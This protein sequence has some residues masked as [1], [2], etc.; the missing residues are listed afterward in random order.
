MDKYKI[1]VKGIV[2]YNDKYLIVEK[3]Y[4]DRI[5]DPYQ[6]EF[7]DGK[8]EFGESP[9]KGVIRLI[10]QSTGLGAE[11]SKILYT[12]SFM[13]G[14]VCNLGITY[15]CLSA[16]EEVIL[17]EELNSYKWITKEEFGDYID[18]KAML[19]DIEKAELIM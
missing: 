7:V 11:I 9:D 18:N 8:V 15:L 6:W 16:S 19:Q 10:Q 13:M 3:W 5:V 2:Q 1:M 14:D 4:D 17:S 12:W